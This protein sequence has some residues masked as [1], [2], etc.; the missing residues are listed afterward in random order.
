MRHALMKLWKMKASPTMF[1]YH[2]SWRA[3]KVLR[4][5][6]SSMSQKRQINNPKSSRPLLDLKPARRSK[7]RR[8]T[9]R[10]W[11]WTRSPS[12]RT[13]S[14]SAS[15]ATRTSPNYATCSTTW[16]R[17]KVRDPSS[18]NIATRPSVNAQTETATRLWRCASSAPQPNLLTLTAITTEQS[19][20]ACRT[21]TT[22]D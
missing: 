19:I 16:E 3:Q 6:N 5:K 21:L 2:I 11:S 17:I 9:G 20:F 18:A 8:A 4:R 12:A 1:R 10:R 13:R 15:P 14:F 22:I 7:K